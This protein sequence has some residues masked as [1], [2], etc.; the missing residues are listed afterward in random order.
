MRIQKWLLPILPMAALLMVGC[1]SQKV[2]DAV[3]ADLQ[4]TREALAT[5]T[6]QLADQ[7]ATLEQT[8]KALV[9]CTRRESDAKER[10]S[11]LEQHIDDLNLNLAEMNKSCEEQMREMSFELD[12][13]K[14]IIELQ[15][16][17]I[18]RLDDTK[19]K[20][21]KSL[22]EQIEAKEIRIEEMENRLKVTMV[23]EILFDTGQAQ[24]NPRGREV[25]LKIADSLR[26]QT[27]H[28]VVVEGHTD[29]V[30]IGPAL[31]NRYASNWELS[32][33]RAISVVRFL[34]EKADMDPTRLSAAA[35]G[36]YQ[37]VAPND[38]A[39]GRK[40]NRRIEIILEPAADR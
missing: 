16:N 18:N 40:R 29:N 34:Q 13:Q 24:V 22:K 35:F 30:P 37:P 32:A 33:A 8:K 6:K 15:E 21:E 10:L 27:S 1:V 5:E 4:Q 11:Q 12:K 28:D 25:L 39:E 26:S 36:P 3:Q 9:E 14:S 7:S 2:H 20:I 23:D 19:Q 31:Q 17:V 38:T